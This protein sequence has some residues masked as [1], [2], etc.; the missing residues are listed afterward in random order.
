MNWLKRKNQTEKVSA[1]QSSWCVIVQKV[2]PLF[3]D[4][5]IQKVTEVFHVSDEF[6][7]QLME[8][9]PIMILDQLDGGKASRVKDFFQEA[10]AE[11][12]V[13]SEERT[14][15]KCFRVDWQETPDLS[16]LGETEAGAEI[17]TA[18][19][20]PSASPDRDEPVVRQDRREPAEYF[21][22]V[23][24]AR[25]PERVYSEE[26]RDVR[27]EEKQ[28]EK[29]YAV[30]MK[31]AE[32]KLSSAT[33]ELAEARNKMAHY[34]EDA[35]QF[36][37]SKVI[38]EKS[39][40]E[41]QFALE[42]ARKNA[43]IYEQDKNLLAKELENSKADCARL[44]EEV[45]SLR[46]QN[47]SLRE[48]Q[49]VLVEIKENLERALTE[50]QKTLD[51]TRSLKIALESEKQQMS[52]SAEDARLHARRLEEKNLSVMTFIEEKKAVLRRDLEAFIE[53]SE[54]L[55]RKFSS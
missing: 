55:K 25:E 32:E 6:S 17:E 49:K 30:E 22:S 52:R 38:L 2:Q 44:T 37:R 24:A 36:Q 51:L 5:F 20:S 14:K 43:H 46:L 50:T 47:S 8:R 33:M 12:I 39:L 11:I 3:R 19:E 41:C 23:P 28:R 10:G 48:E 26:P 7:S 35:T 45:S 21:P 27:R 53:G 42:T 29:I 40:A 4:K 31:H 15:K 9:T 54:E 13:T 1:E 16:F 34:A 18:A